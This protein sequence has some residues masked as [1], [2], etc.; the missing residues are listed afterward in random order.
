MIPWLATQISL[1]VGITTLIDS[2]LDCQYSMTNIDLTS[3]IF[4][5]Y[6]ITRLSLESQMYGL[7]S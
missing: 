7:S 4:N 3:T 5:P 6:M 1:V 2:H